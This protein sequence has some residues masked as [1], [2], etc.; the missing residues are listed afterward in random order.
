MFGPTPPFGELDGSVDP[1]SPFGEL[2]GSSGLT[3]L[4]G[5]LDNGCFSVRDP[6]PE[7]L[8]TNPLP[9]T[10]DGLYT[11]RYLLCDGLFF[12]AT[13]TPKRVRRTAALHRSRF[14]SDLPVEEGEES[15]MDGFVPYEAPTE[16]G[17]IEKRIWKQWEPIPVSL[18]MVEAETGAPNDT[19]EVNQPSVPLSVN[20]FS[21]GGGI[22]DQV[23]RV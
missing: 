5:E 18:D 15:S 9:P 4:F 16:R 23:L 13:F 17:G 8:M 19:G 20:D 6:M 11:I 22:D 1:T 3:R 14:Q 2:V 21:M 12:W 7:A 10:P